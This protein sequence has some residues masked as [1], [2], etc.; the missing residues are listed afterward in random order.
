MP[1]CVR[2]LTTALIVILGLLVFA[3]VGVGLLRTCGAFRGGEGDDNDSLGVQ[4]A[5][6]VQKKLR[7][8]LAALGQA[9]D[10][11][12]APA[13]ELKGDE[14]VHK[15]IADN[16]T[17]VVEVYGSWCGACQINEPVVQRASRLTEI[18]F[19]KA[20]EGTLDSFCQAFGVTGFPTFIR[21]KGGKEESRISGGGAAR[22]AKLLEIE[23][24]AALTA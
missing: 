14:A 7:K 15:F 20:E 4:H 16:D 22:I 13:L 1:V 6:N 12:G 5:K 10:E 18:P 23:D 11:S 2:P 3:L 19:A 9:G 21:F 17:C 24:V 8:H